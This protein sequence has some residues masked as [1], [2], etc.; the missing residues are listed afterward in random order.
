MSDPLIGLS[1]FAVIYT[2]VF[3]Q[4]DPAKLVRT[5]ASIQTN[6]QIRSTTVSCNV[7]SHNHR[8]EWTMPMDAMAEIQLLI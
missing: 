7:L 6:V 1:C 8:T 4:K 3:Y 2:P 5:A